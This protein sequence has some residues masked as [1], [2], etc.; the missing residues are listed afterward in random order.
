[1]IQSNTS[2]S[3]SIGKARRLRRLLN[4]DGHFCVVALDQRAILQQMLAQAHEIAES[5]LPFRDM[6]A[7]KRLLVELLSANASA[8]LFDPNIAVPAALDILPRD[9]GL[10]VSLEHHIVEETSIGRKTHSIPDWSIDKIQ[11]LG[12]DG[13]KVLLWY[14]PQAH[15]EILE[16]QKQYVQEIGRQCEEHQLP[17]VLE[18]LAYQPP[19]HTAAQSIASIDSIRTRPA[20]VLDSVAEFTQKQY[21]VDLLKLESPVPVHSLYTDVALSQ[22]AFDAIGECCQAAQIPWVLLSGG[23]TTREFATVLEHAYA[24]GAQGF[25]AGRAIW[26]ESLQAFP[27]MEVCR[28]NLQSD[29]ITALEQLLQITRTQARAYAPRQEPAPHLQEQ[30]DFA[31]WYARPDSR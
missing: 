13:V 2:K 19:A 6:L 5:D 21:R 11:R 24:A 12:A 14:H 23:V 30:G 18:L 3:H 15:D 22:R 20:V 1:M 26:K 8:M 9:T 25:L 4:E 10:L 27:D 17:F 16:H 31:N 7:V 29:G 28:S